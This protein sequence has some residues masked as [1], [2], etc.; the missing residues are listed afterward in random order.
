M[1][2]AL[3]LWGLIFAAEATAADV[4]FAEDSQIVFATVEQGAKFSHGATTS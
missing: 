3:F 2:A 4:P 1:C